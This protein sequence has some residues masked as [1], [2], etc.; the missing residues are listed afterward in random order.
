MNKKKNMIV[1]IDAESVSSVYCDEI[2]VQSR[3]IGQLDEVRYYARQKD[4]STRA[5]SSKANLHNIRKFLIGG[6]PSPNKID[7][8]I[9]SDAK[10]VADKQTNIDIFCI[11]TRDGDYTEL[12]NYLRSHGKRVVIL[13]TKYTSQKLKRAASEVRDI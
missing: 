11:A 7:K 5:W 12:V 9:I 13:A 2:M 3:S 1:F 6:G 10:K 4:P 8:H